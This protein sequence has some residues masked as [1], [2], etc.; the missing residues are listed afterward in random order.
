M[1]AGTTIYLGVNVEGA[2]FSIGDGHYRQGEGEACGIAVE[3]AMDSVILVELIKGAAPL[4]PRLENDDYWMVAGSSRPMEDA[5]R[6]AQTEMVAWFTELFGLDAMDAYQLLTQISLTPIA[7][8]V[9][10]NYSVVV[11]APKSLMPDTLAY[12][13]IHTYLRELAPVATS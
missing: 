11:K 1:K 10:D 12:D 9:D 6:I 13:G 7:N 8:A 3:G 5:W 4:W 2:L